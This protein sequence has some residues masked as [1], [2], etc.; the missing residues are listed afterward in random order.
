VYVIEIKYKIKK[1]LEVVT[2]FSDPTLVGK[3]L[4][5]WDDIVSYETLSVSQ[6]KASIECA[7][8]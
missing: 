3:M 5:H 6:I 7:K 1:G 8:L 4:H 2:M